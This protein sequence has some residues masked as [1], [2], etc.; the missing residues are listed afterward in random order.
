M[1]IRPVK[2]AGAQNL[3]IYFGLIEPH[4]QSIST[5][6]LTCFRH[7]HHHHHQDP[8]ERKALVQSLHLLKTDIFMELVEGGALPLRPGVSRLVRES[9]TAEPP[10]PGT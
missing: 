3:V 4:N 6:L 9:R 8:E 2:P 5:H 1:G 10:L 7:H